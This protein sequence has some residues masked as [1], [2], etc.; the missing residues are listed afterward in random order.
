MM[1]ARLREIA[2]PSPEPPYCRVTELSA[3]TKG[4]KRLSCTSARM[5]IP[6]SA[7][8]TVSVALISS[9]F[10]VAVT[11][12]CTRPCLVNL[13]ALD[14]RL[15]THWRS[16][17][18]SSIRFCGTD[19]STWLVNVTSLASIVGRHKSSMLVIMARM[20]ELSG[21]TSISLASIRDISKI[22]STKLNKS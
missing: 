22:C 7:T 3:C 18:G 9:S 15:L 4:R 6:V 8:M 10:G 5:P 14:T 11:C 2:S 21:K 20:S 1:R 16:R 17:I 13:A 19:E 12:M